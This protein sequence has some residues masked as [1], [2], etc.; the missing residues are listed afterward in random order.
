MLERCHAVGL[1]DDLTEYILHHMAT[2]KI[3]RATR[4]HFQRHV[5][6]PN[7][8]EVRSSVVN[9]VGVAG[10]YIFTCSEWVRR[11]WRTEP[12]SWIIAL[13]KDLHLILSEVMI[14]V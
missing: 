5:F 4:R 14:R 2:S 9:T 11:E 1:P 13:D 8:K 6:H 12:E 3:Q 7:W 10:F